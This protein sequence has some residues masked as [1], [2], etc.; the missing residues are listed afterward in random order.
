MEMLL[1]ASC[2]QGRSGEI[3]SCHKLLLH[4]LLAAVGVGVLG[5]LIC[6]ES[7]P[8]NDRVTS[9]PKQSSDAPATVSTVPS[10]VALATMSTL[11]SR[12]EPATVS[13]QP[14]GDRVLV[15]S[16]ESIYNN[17]YVYRTGT[18]VSMTFGHNQDLFEES[19]YNTTDDRELPVPYTQF[20]TASLIYPSKVNSILEIG[21]GGGRTAW[22]LHRSL[23]KVQVTTV[24]LD[25]TVVELSRRYFGI[26]DEPNFRIVTRDGRMFLAGS[27][28]RYDVILIDAYRGP[29]VPFH[30]LTTEFYQSVK[31]HLA[32]GG[33][34]AENVEPK[35][36]LFDSA[37]KTLHAVF[38][39]VEFYDASGDNVG[40][41]V[42]MIAYDGE[43]L[44]TSDLRRMAETHQFDYH[45]RYDLAQ[46]LPHRFLLKPVG[47]SFDVVNQAGEQTAGIDDKAK[48]L[49]DDFA[50][51]ESLKAIARHNQKWTFQ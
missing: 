10:S 2:R 41:N 30:L 32:K 8:A 21:S 18:Y 48:V 28:D 20:M 13:P 26:K 33:V 34:I 39:Q 27:K 42:V 50:P 22:Y 14:S 35:T 25:P 45:L 3:M 4:S 1:K 46:M 51:V 23:P 6:C 40:G 24:E 47:S 16:K 7:T 44:S 11:P 37:V 9:P 17:I 29:F 49:T 5:S 12:V 43:E 36:M 15:E 19:R 38:P 31:G